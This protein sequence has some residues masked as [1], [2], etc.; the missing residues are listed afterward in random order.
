MWYYHKGMKLVSWTTHTISLIIL[1]S[2]SS[3]SVFLHSLY[4]TK[5]M[6][7]YIKYCTSKIK[8]LTAINNTTYLNVNPTDI[9]TF[10]N[11]ALILEKKEMTGKHLIWKLKKS[12]QIYFCAQSQLY[13]Q[14]K[15]PSS[16]F[17][18]LYSLSIC[19]FHI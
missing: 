13:M 3:I 10:C 4:N 6:E 18:R 7:F 2:R 16:F 11:I 1:H 17:K 12:Y 14:H 9:T 8:L 15:I 5:G 19:I